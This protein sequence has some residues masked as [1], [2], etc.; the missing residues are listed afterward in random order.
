MY[1]MNKYRLLILLCVLSVI[2]LSV[3]ANAVGIAYN[4]FLC[5]DRPIILYE[6]EERTVSLWLQNSNVEDEKVRVKILNNEEGIIDINEK[7]YVVEAGTYDTE[8]KFKLRI[9]ENVSLGTRYDM[10]LNFLNVPMEETGG[11][12]LTT[13]MNV[14]VCV[15]VGEYVA[16]SPPPG[17]STTTWIILAIIAVVILAAIIIFIRKKK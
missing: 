7:D 5:P 11:I 17:F 2:G 10:V 16:T 1:K 14:N 9:P 12:A 6:G 4:D 3:N 13:A 15:Q 8:L